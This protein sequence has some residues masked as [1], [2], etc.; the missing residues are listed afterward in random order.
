VHELSIAMSIVELAQEESQR[1]GGLRITA[2]HLRLGLLA[3]V[4]RDALLFSYQAAC[5][6]TSLAG[7]QLVVEEVPG[8][9]YCRKCAARRPVRSWEWFVCSECGSPVSEIVQGKELEV[10][11]LEVEQ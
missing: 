6:N 11:S 5:E 4:G 1:R 7:S 2:V 10:V 8:L 3:G 9:V